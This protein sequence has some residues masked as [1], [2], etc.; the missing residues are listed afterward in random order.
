MRLNDDD[1]T[2][3]RTS[4]TEGTADASAGVPVDPYEQD[5]GADGTADAEGPLDAGADEPNNPRITDGGADGG[6]ERSA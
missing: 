2:T 5:G 1:I 3:T 6:A 4:P